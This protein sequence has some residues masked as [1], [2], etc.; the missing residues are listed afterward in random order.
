MP[1]F[2]GRL[3]LW[4]KVTGFAF[5]NSARVLRLAGGACQFC[6]REA[7][8][9][10]GGY[11]DEHFAAED[12]VFIKALKRQGRVVIL[13]EPVVTSGRSLRGHSWLKIWWLLTKLV[14]IGPDGFRNRERAEI[15]YE[16]KRENG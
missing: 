5:V 2:E 6:T 9:A 8:A 7:F 3:P 14:I 12:L 15:W 1:R 11:S 10:T 16:P 4:W 13:A